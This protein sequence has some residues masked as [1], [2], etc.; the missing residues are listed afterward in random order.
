MFYFKENA[1]PVGK[2]HQ[3]DS[4]ERMVEELKKVWD[5][6]VSSK[7]FWGGV[8]LSKVTNFLLYCMDGLV[9]AVAD[10][11]ISGPDKKATV[12]A[13]IERLYDYTV[14]EALPIWMRPIAGPIKSYVINVLISSAIDWVVMKYKSGSWQS[15]SAPKSSRKGARRSK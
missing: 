13:A 3:I 1:D 7:S 4:V 11:V 10:S 15:K 6:R 5:D 8:S 9:T 2:P 12:L 14:R